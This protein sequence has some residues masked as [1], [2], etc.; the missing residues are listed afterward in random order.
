[1]MSSSVIDILVLYV[2]LFTS[3]TESCNK[4]C[5]VNSVSNFSKWKSATN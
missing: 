4:Q 1:M 3:E 5:T 2:L